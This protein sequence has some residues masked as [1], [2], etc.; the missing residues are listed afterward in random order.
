MFVFV[1]F[2]LLITIAFYIKKHKR[3]I[4]NTTWYTEI[5]KQVHAQPAPKVVRPKLYVVSLCYA[6]LIT[7][8]AVA[9]LFYLDKLLAHPV[10]SSPSGMLATVLM[11]FIAVFSLPY[12]LRLDLSPLFRM[13]SFI[14]ACILPLCWLSYLVVLG[15]LVDEVGLLGAVTPGGW[16]S[17]GIAMLGLIGTMLTAVALGVPRLK[18]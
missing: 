8:V 4:K 11:I 15:R 13:L 7:V 12:V 17:Y 6:L 3:K 14:F 16:M 1:T 5:M 18:R 10:V 9:Q 2:R